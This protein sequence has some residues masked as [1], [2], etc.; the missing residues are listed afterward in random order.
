MVVVVVVVVDKESGEK[1][2]VAFVHIHVEY[3]SLFFYKKFISLF[4]I[5]CYNLHCYTRCKGFAAFL[6][7]FNGF[8]T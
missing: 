1:E 7:L 4:D 6:L 5:V 3:K 8:S 2:I